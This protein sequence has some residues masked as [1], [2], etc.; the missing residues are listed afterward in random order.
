VGLEG[1]FDPYASYFGSLEF[2]PSSPSE[3]TVEL[4]F[5][6]LCNLV[7]VPNGFIATLAAGD[8]TATLFFYDPNSIV[9][10]DVIPAVCNIVGGDLTCVDGTATQ[11]LV[12]LN[13]QL[14]LGTPGDDYADNFFY[15]AVVS[16]VLQP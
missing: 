13:G 15:P 8:S 12:E 16:A 2:E 7:M 14:A 3:P 9:Q 4:T 10:N 5:N 1:S 6:D 11:V